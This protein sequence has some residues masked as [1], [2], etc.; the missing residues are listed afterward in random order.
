MKRFNN[1]LLVAKPLQT[2]PLALAAALMLAEQNTA[3]ITVLLVLPPLNAFHLIN[4]DRSQQDIEQAYIQHHLDQLL[5]WI[6]SKQHDVVIRCKVVIG[7]E[8][9]EIIRS[10]LRNQHDLVIKTAEPVS[11]I[12]RLFGSTD[13]H[14]L[15]K[16][17][18]PLWLLKPDVAPNYTKV[19]ASV[20]IHQTS[21]H[22][23]P[24]LNQDIV[25][26]ASA[27]AIHNNAELYIL[28]AWQPE[29]AGM[30]LMWCDNPEQA[31]AEFNQSVYQNQ[32]TA[33]TRFKNQTVEW[34]GQQ[35]YDFSKPHF[36][37]IRGETSQV[38]A[39]RIAN[40]EPGLVIMG[41][42]ARTGIAGFLIGN[43]AE[44]ILEQLNCSVLAIKPKGFITPVT[45]EN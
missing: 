14:L 44:A 8:F 39:E 34:L 32:Q 43:T 42:L 18:C 40:I 38:L 24:S 23:E 4:K 31:E 12:K 27:F 45:L 16:C 35:A 7:T 3:E 11:W 15:R 37:L 2:Q 30:V 41:T 33:M 19:V 28:N 17:P 36:E 25:T 9:I 29:P 21:T 20:D 22:A 13:M 26:L 10:V 6:A 5:A 1:I